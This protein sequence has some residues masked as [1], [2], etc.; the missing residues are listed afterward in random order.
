MYFYDMRSIY[1]YMSIKAKL[2]EVDISAI[3]Y[4]DM[5]LSEYFI[6]APDNEHPPMLLAFYVFVM[7]VACIALILIIRNAFLVSMQPGLKDIFSIILSSLLNLF[8]TNME[9]RSIYRKEG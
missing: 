6:F 1:K 2:I 7:A 8:P 9:R 3:Q 4:H 5:L